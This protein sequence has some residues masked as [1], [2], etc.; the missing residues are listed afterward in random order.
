MEENN[1]FEIENNES[2][3]SLGA[4][5]EINDGAYIEICEED[6][7]D[8]AAMTISID[9][10]DSKEMEETNDEDEQESENKVNW[11]KE[12]FEWIGA[13]AAAIIIVALIKGFLFDFIVVDGRSMQT[14]LMNNDRLILTKLAYTPQK[15]DI[16]VLDANYK[17]RDKYIETQKEL[18]GESFTAFDEFKLRNF[19]WEQKKFG[20]EPL[21]YVKRII[22][23]EGDVID[24]DNT[25]NTVTVNGQIIDEPYLDN[26]KTYS[27]IEIE[28]PYTVEEGHAFVMGDNREDSRDSRYK[29]PGTIPY[30]AILGKASLRFW[31]LNNFGIVD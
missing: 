18:K 7:C 9:S 5:I 28:F 14:T 19:S 31:P 11:L 29:M 21:H 27:G 24:I 30:E 17:L 13:L 15:G 23:L 10:Q 20:I 12:I 4:D 3:Q 1:N 2:E 8:D 16:V 25:T 22:A 6:E 26:V